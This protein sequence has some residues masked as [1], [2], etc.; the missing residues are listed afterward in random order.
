MNDALKGSLERRLGPRF[1]LLPDGRAWLA[2]AG[3]AELRMVVTQY[4]RFG[5]P[6]FGN[7]ELYR[8]ALSGI[9]AV[10]AQSGVIEADAGVT[11]AAID[12]AAEPHGFTVGALSPR[13]YALDLAAF[14]EGPYAGLRPVL[15]GRLEP[16]CLALEAIL[17]D[18][19][20]FASR[21]APRSA[22]GPD[23]DALLLGGEGRFGWVS[24]ASVRLLPRPTL[25]RRV[26]YGFP[27]G[28][29][30]ATA[31]RRLLSAGCHVRC[32]WA[33]RRGGRVLL[34]LEL[35]GS[36]DAIERDLSTCSNE[37]AEAGGRASGQVLDDAPTG[38]EREL[39]WGDVVRELETGGRL[40]LFRLS[41]DA[42]V[43]IGATR[44][45][46][47]AAGQG[48]AS[49]GTWAEIASA[50]APQEGAGPARSHSGEGE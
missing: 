43:A 31:A 32:G 13:A 10:E 24:R 47:L 42:V 1:R 5:E 29:T 8:A 14:L 41:S 12:R 50:L 22:A 26:V 4:H 40:A 30:L 35:A 11:L 9:G 44:G 18:G 3:D 33:Q 27:D 15:G 2:P 46:R 49:A 39:S 20:P 6:L 38:E 21:P 45:R 25:T 28:G 23:L 36:A 17:P 34:E 48:W 37:V 19:L 7:A 16:L